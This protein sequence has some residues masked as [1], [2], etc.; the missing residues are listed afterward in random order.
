MCACART[1][2]LR[3][4]VTPAACALQ[5]RIALQVLQALVTH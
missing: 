1:I 4:G 3:G 2:A 5:E